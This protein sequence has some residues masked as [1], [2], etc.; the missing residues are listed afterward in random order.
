MLQL[1]NILYKMHLNKYF[2]FSDSSAF[3]NVFFPKILKQL[4][5][6]LRKTSFWYVKEEFFLMLDLSITMKQH[7]QERVDL[8]WIYFPKDVSSF[9][10]HHVIYSS[11]IH[12]SLTF[13]L[14]DH[15]S[16]IFVWRKKSLVLY[17]RNSCELFADLL[18]L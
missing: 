11:S 14:D 4:C 13:S 7:C 9:L 17:A 15:H 8:S 6:S 2:N 12:I 18:P 1:F 10:Y 3:K 16:G 5:D